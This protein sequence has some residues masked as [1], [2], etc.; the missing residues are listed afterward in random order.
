MLRRIASLTVFLC[1]LVAFIEAASASHMHV[2]K[3]LVTRSN[4]LSLPSEH[5]VRNAFSQATISGAQNLITWLLTPPNG[6]H[7]PDFITL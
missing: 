5:S 7:I 4:H 6:L 2:M 1:G 3:W